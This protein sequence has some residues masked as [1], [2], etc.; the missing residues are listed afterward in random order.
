MNNYLP[1]NKKLSTSK[2]K[3]IK[4]RF[5]DDEGH[6]N[7]AGCTLYVEARLLDREHLLPKQ[8]TEHLESCPKCQLE[9]LDFYELMQDEDPE[10]IEIHPLLKESKK[11]IIL[12]KALSYT[13]S[14]SRVA[15]V[16]LLTVV[17]SLAYLIVRS[18]Q[19]VEN[20][21]LISPFEKESLQV[22]F[23]EWEMQAEEARYFF[24]I[25]WIFDSNTC[26]CICR[27]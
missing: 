22:D 15:A 13:S 5:F 14:L 7:D 9:V 18:P 1:R 6:L 26:F 17:S 27:F 16:I 25:Q 12:R 24:T 11:T 19:P 4:D 8:I 2:S 3:A 21:G 23:Q 20:Q 10:S